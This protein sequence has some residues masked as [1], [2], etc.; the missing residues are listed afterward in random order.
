MAAR[1]AITHYFHDPLAPMHP[2][3]VKMVLLIGIP[4]DG[5]DLPVAAWEQQDR[6]GLSK[7]EKKRTPAF[8]LTEDDDRLSK[9]QMRSEQGGRA[10][11]KDWTTEA[12]DYSQSTSSRGYPLG[13]CVGAMKP[14]VAKKYAQEGKVP[15]ITAKWHLEAELPWA[16]PLR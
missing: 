4:S 6:S 8:K 7:S 16:R 11:E 3:V 15:M 5:G 2:W 9:R 13:I 14:K 10:R 12:L 1:Y